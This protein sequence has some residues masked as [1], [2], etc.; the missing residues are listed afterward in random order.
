M[1]WQEFRNGLNQRYEATS[2]QDFF[3]ELIKL[4]QVG[5]VNEY[6]TQFERLL[7][8]VGHL[9]QNRQISCFIS[10]LHDSIKAN[11]LACCPTTLSSAIGLACLYEARNLSQRRSMQTS[12]Q[13]TYRNSSI[14][15]RRLSQAELQERRAK[16]LCYNC[17]EKFVPGHRCKKLF[18]ID[19]CLEEE[20]GDV[21]MEVEE[22]VGGNSSKMPE[23][24]LRAIL[25]ARASET[26]RI[27]GRIGNIS[28]II[29]VDSGST[30]NF[31]SDVFANKVG[32][33]SES[34]SRFEVLV[35]SG[36]KLYS[37]GKCTNVKLNL[38]GVSMMGDFYLLTLEGYEIVLGTQWLWT[39]GPIWWD[40]AMLQ[41]RFKL[42]DKE[43]TIKKS[44]FQMM[45]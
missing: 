19:A 5:S 8:K 2:F 7:A 28:T 11:V 9:P 20:D 13:N 25:G 33:Q 4:R 30:H 12:N 34:R 24:S 44:L 32:L 18:L 23:I 6:Q 42:A 26:M 45:R 10:G 1:T 17:N 38:Q 31:M 14:P 27:K 22:N 3:G 21:I 36:E 43:I 29:L 16:G 35:A 15:V 41:M 37:P 39:L 40:F